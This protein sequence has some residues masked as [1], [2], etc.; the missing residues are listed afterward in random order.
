EVGLG[1][2]RKFSTGRPIF[3][4]LVDNVPVAA[5]AFYELDWETK[6]QKEREMM[7]LQRQAK[8]VKK[9]KKGK[10]MAKPKQQVILEEKTNDAHVEEGMD[11]YFSK[12]VIPEVTTYLLVPLA[13]TPTGRTPLPSN[14]VEHG[15]LL[16][17]PTV[18]RIHNDHQLHSCRV[19]ALFSRLDAAN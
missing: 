10:E 19:A 13:P 7:R 5:R 17:L 9:T 1:T 15:S 4:H 18:A 8:K 11:Q 16:P 3:Q 2:A 12:E 14:T 6:M